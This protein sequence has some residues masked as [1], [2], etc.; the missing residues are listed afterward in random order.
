[1]SD[2]VQFPPPSGSASQVL[3]QALDESRYDDTVFVV[4][5]RDGETCVLSSQFEAMQLSHA[6]TLLSAYAQRQALDN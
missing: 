6:A 5:I 2:I 1:M 3:R 4:T